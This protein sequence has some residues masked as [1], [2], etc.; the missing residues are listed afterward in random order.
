MVWGPERGEA[1]AGSVLE[2]ASDGASGVTCDPTP[3]PPVSSA[4]SCRGHSHKAGAPRFAACS[5][6]QL[7]SVCPAADGS[8]VISSWG[9]WDY[10][11]S[12]IPVR[13]LSP[14]LA[15]PLGAHLGVRSMHGQFSA[16]VVPVLA[17]VCRVPTA[18][19]SLTRTRIPSTLSFTVEHS[20]GCVT[21]CISLMAKETKCF[22]KC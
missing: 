4:H 1:S 16:A 13:L 6:A 22:C 2:W 19:S 3:F 18:L 10:W 17:A 7:L 11:C 12:G 21:V 5:S 9:S 15:Q 20:G 14:T 8:P